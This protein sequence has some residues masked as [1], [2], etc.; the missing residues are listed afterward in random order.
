MGENITKVPFISGVSVFSSGEI[1]P[2]LNVSDIIKHSS[3]ASSAAISEPVKSAET[4]GK[5]KKKR[6]L[7]AED[8]PTSRT[9]IKNVLEAASFEV[10]TT[11]DGQEAFTYLKTNKVDLLVSD[12]EMPR[13]D[14]FTL[15]RQV[16][17]SDKF[18]E[19]PIILVTSLSR[20]E[21]M[22]KGIEAGANS[23]IIKSQ[24]DQSVLI[25]TV[26]SLI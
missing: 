17:S 21:D 23:Y 3:S 22:E 5:K 18:K 10:I 8:S 12:I 25:D 19:L 11:N 16:R 9:L 24:F 13:M 15:T 20:R 1:V 14:G 2:I 4:S 26:K 6:I 7:I